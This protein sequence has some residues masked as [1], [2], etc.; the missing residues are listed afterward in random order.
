MRQHPRMRTI[1]FL[2]ALCVACD[3]APESAEP[4]TSPD[5]TNE[6]TTPEPADEAA[7]ETTTGFI[8]A[9]VDGESKRF[10]YLPARE[11]MVYTRLTKMEA[12]AGPDSEEGFELL[13]MGIDVR[14]LELPAVIRG[15]MREAVRGNL[16][17]AQRMPS[18]KYRNTAGETSIVIF[19]DDSLECQSLE[20]L[21]LS[22][23]FSA[24][25]NGDAGT[26]EVTNGR[27]QVTLGS[28]QL[29]DSFTDN[30]V[31]RAA[32]ESVERVQMV[33]DRRLG[34]MN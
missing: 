18:L 11:N 30:T 15:G 17:A 32:D 26:I 19:N 27:L 1:V 5:P 3:D 4:S 9:T 6:P 24:T 34:K 12:K 29:A 20:G 28:D 7:P 8:E 2:L 21:V 31:G 14:Q 10:E 25:L 22:C 16:A 33:I 13:L 23:T